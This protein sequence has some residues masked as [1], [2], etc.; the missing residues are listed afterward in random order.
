MT[1]IAIPLADNVRCRMLLAELEQ[2]PCSTLDLQRRLPLV[3]VARQIW[4]LRHWYG[5]RIDTGRLENRVAVYTLVVPAP[6]N[7][8]RGR[9]AI[10]AG[11]MFEA[12]S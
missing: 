4:E 6:T 2:G 11:G 12:A 1:E 5:F 3:H 9:E 7:V 8:V 10:A